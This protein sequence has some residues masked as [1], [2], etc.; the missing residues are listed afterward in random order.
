MNKM[1]K[2]NSAV[3][4]IENYVAGMRAPTSTGRGQ[5][6]FNPATGEVTAHVGYSNANDVD[7]AVTAAKRALAA[8]VVG[9]MRPIEI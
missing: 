8:M 3:T 9:P 5:D 2:A 4:K 1:S 6:I 7:A